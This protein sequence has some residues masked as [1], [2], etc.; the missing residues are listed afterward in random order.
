V[1]NNDLFLIAI[2]LTRRCNLACEHCY[3]DAEA[4]LDGGEGELSTEE[5]KS[6]LDEITSRSN[7]TM[8]VLTGG[9]PLIRNDIE[10]LVR[11]G[12]Q[13]GLS[14]VIGTNGVLLDEKRVKSLKAAGAMGVGISLDSLDPSHHDHFRGCTG[15]WEKTLN[16]ME[17]CRQNNLPFQVHFSVT[18][19][20]A[21][22]VQPMID[23]TKA[24]GAHVLNIFFLVCT[25]RGESMSDIT[26]FRYEQV[27]QQLVEAQEQNQD[28]I[29]RARCA[30]HYKRVAYQ[31]NPESTLTRAEGYEGGGCLAGLH[32]CRIT[33]EGAVTACPYIPDEDGSIRKESF[34]QIWD[35]APTFKQLRN[36]TLNG[37]CG[38]CE[39]QKLCG[40]C[41][42]RPLAMGGS[43]MDADPWC[44]HTPSSVAMIEPLVVENNSQVTWSPEAEKRLERVPGFL[45]KMVRKRAEAHVAELGESIITTKHMATLAARRFGDKFPGQRPN[46]PG[47]PTVEP[48]EL[49]SSNSGL[50]WTLEAKAHLETIPSF[51]REGV[52]QVAEDVA[53]SE[54]RLEVNMQ[55][56]NRLDEEC[57]QSR[58]LPWHP[59]AE[60]QLEAFLSSRPKQASIFIQPSMEAAAEREAKQRGAITVLAEDVAKI[61]ETQLAGVSW[62]NDALKR[63]E[64]A[65]DFVRAGIKKAAEFSARREGLT[66]I[67]CDSLTRFRNKAMMRAVKRMKGFGMNELS[68]DGFAIAKEQ[69]PRLQEN[70]QA[71][72]RFAEIQ[73]YVESKQGEDGS[74][75]GLLDRELLN[76]MKAELKG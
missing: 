29:I 61:I 23:F 4:R 76:K 33:P 53:H 42:A 66:E 18:E 65:P 38:Q 28:L 63:V 68:F 13:L 55:L 72:K 9:E 48:T 35:N 22:E 43:L 6:L 58:T 69:V 39:F 20:N 24:S 56:L 46:M 5:V 51:L 40:G 47:M 60:E 71:E 25:G 70:S 30:P 31:H 15:S 36:P 37:K 62:K 26:P 73:S 44:S 50:A 11:H 10:A 27:L 64:S 1:Q 54:G 67:D 57:D 75:L 7:E 52:F 74:G 17:L 59:E 12:S 14:V 8:V 2:N 45:R 34:W 16:G 49:Q 41:R 19:K 21:H 3:M 32:Y